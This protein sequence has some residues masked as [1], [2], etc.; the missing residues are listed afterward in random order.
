VSAAP[1]RKSYDGAE[2]GRNPTSRAG[3]L[4]VTAGLG[5][6]TLTVM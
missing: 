3:D 2:F 6:R 1:A 5:G 4:I